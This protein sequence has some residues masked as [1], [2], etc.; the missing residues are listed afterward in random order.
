[1]IPR[2]RALGR[3]RLGSGVTLY[4]AFSVSHPTNALRTLTNM[5]FQLS[6]LSL[7][8]AQKVIAQ[9]GKKRTRRAC[10]HTSPFAFVPHPSSLVFA[11][12]TSYRFC[13]PWHAYFLLYV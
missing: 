12:S 7:V 6:V 9:R 10:H 11:N 8:I 5:R 3:G 13:G 2:V 1:M 4:L